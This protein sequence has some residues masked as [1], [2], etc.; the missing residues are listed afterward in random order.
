MRSGLRRA[1]GM[2]LLGLGVLLG[3]PAM[4]ENAPHPGWYVGVGLGVNWLS[5]MDQ[6]GWNRDSFCYPMDD[7][8]NRDTIEGYRWFYDLDTDR[9][10]LFEVVIGRGFGNVRLEVSANRREND[11]DQKFT[12]ITYV[13]GSPILPDPTSNYTSQSEATIDR[14]R[15]QTLQLNAYYDFPLAHSP[16]TPYMGVGVG[17]SDVK[18]YGLYFR[19]E[20]SCTSGCDAKLS[21]PEAYNSWQ[22]EDLSDTVFSM[23]LHA[24]ADYSLGDK[25][26][27]GLKLTYSEMDDMRDTGRYIDHPLP[28]EL[29]HTKIS[30]MDHWSLTLGLKYRLGG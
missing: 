22:D 2:V 3:A 29:N 24:G 11:I 13:D 25:L 10:N 12:D 27:L 26:L 1:C 16:I 19:S 30:D 20:Y 15:T 9:G 14:L 5:K 4:A 7:C 8:S 17:L 23:H 18:L 21:P 6:A 28:D